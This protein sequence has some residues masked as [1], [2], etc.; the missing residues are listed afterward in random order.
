MTQATYGVGKPQPVVI[1]DENNNISPILGS[2]GIDQTT[3][4]TTN[5]VVVNSSALPSGAATSAKQDLL[6]TEL[7]LKAD[8]TETQPVSLATNTP[9]GTIA[10]NAADS[11]NP[12]KIG[13]KYNSA[14]QTYADGDR[15]DL[16]GDLHGNTLISQG[17]LIHGEDET[18]DV[19]KVSTRYA[20]AYI[21]TA[22]TTVVKS[23]EAI[24][25]RIIVNGGT[26]GTITVYDNTAASGSVIA[27]F[28]TTNALAVYEFGC[29]CST[30][31][32][33]VTSAATKLTVLY[34]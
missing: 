31:I 29:I 6:L 34:V 33:I 32:T 11:G 20:S 30:G 2:I 18:F 21:S 23:G 10:D 1:T 9:L 4:G 7:Q 8:L 16:Q 17:T 26:T 19:M 12:I 27:D 13:G 22:T 25:G 3:P 24:L 14:I 28:D 5:G 15:F